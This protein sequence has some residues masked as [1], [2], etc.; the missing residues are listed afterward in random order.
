[1]GT[2]DD[3]Y[4]N[5]AV[6]IKRAKA[7]YLLPYSRTTSSVTVKRVPLSTSVITYI[8]LL[9]PNVPLFPLKVNVPHLL[10]KLTSDFFLFAD[11]KS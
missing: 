10:E 3:G 4:I 1:M 7:R 11:G 8:P 2:G 9:V 5:T 6:C